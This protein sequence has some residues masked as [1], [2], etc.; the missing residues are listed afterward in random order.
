M[1]IFSQIYD[2]V[3]RWSR[4][5]HA[6]YYLAGV[7][8]AES[9]FFPVPPDVMLASMTLANPDRA[10]W[11][12]LLTTLSSVVGGLVGYL[13]GA[14]FFELAASYMSYLG[15][16]TAYQTVHQWFTQWGFWIVFVAGFSPIPYK[17][18]TIAAGAMHM[19]LLPFVAAS[20]I[21]RGARFFLVAGLLYL[22]GEKF[23]THLRRYIDW[24]G[25]LVV[26]LAVV[27]YFI[28]W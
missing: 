17:L 4:H 5:R 10:W 27:G 9:S 15:Y 23:E 3:L 22:G 21:A 8:F 12:A 25:W 11:Y 7:S 13:I 28:F 16:E 18:F 1:G 26:V 19:A 6:P 24:L 20:L 14:L 2:R